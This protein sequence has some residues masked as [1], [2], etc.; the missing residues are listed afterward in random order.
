M[1]CGTCGSVLKPEMRYCPLCGVSV[2]G[3]SRK[4]KKGELIFEIRQ[5][6]EEKNYSEIAK[7]ALSGNV[8][9][10]YLYIQYAVQ[11]AKTW[12][13]SAEGTADI[14]QALE[15][16]NPAAMAIWG[17]TLYTSYRPKGIFEEIFE[18]PKYN[19]AEFEK[20]ITLVKKAA[21][22]GDAAASSYMGAW[23]AAGSLTQVLKNERDAYKYTQAAVNK[24]YPT[25]M[26]RLGT[27]YLDGINGVRKNPEL[28][29][30]LIERAAF[31]GETSAI[32]YV[33]KYNDKWLET[34]LRVLEDQ[35]Q[36][37][38]SAKLLHSSSKRLTEDI[39]F[40][41]DVDFTYD[42]ITF[43]S[44]YEVAVYKAECDFA[45]TLLFN[46]S[47][48]NDY[49]RALDIIQ[50]TRFSDYDI[51]SDIL[52][53][54]QQICK[55]ARIN[56]D[57][58]NIFLKASSQ[59]GSVKDNEIILNEIPDCLLNQLIPQLGNAKGYLLH[60]N[61]TAILENKK[62]SGMRQSLQITP[63]EP[64]YVVRPY[65]MP[66]NYYT[67]KSKGYAIAKTGIYIKAEHK[68][69]GFMK[70][71]DFG[72]T[73]IFIGDLRGGHIDNVENGQFWINDYTLIL[74]EGKAAQLQFFIS[75][76]SLVKLVHEVPSIP[77]IDYPHP[78]QKVDDNPEKVMTQTEASAE[79]V[80]P[81]AAAQTVPEPVMEVSE[82]IESKICPSCNQKNK[83]T[84]KFC[85]FC[86]SAL[87]PIQFCTQ[88]GAKL[89]P[90]KKFCSSCGAKIE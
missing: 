64:I 66:W 33:K 54:R 4:D 79:V 34:D 73:D 56:K 41:E 17:I 77:Q 11:K 57:S 1:T 67:E 61:G 40:D 81:V 24:E 72:E 26:Y 53:V 86:G 52:K 43:S 20:G 85:K 62:L 37:K 21:N 87:E 58:L 70:W 59:C 90:G 50:A 27:W 74:P 28:G 9:A 80:T 18:G 3:I 49:L 2:D 30:E 36:I 25:A 31:Y 14:K 5:L 23:C 55:L 68:K 83:A 19:D 63:D 7:R 29:Y 82:H 22:L 48:L 45:S 35:K 39:I 88:C 12:T 69:T 75:L 32:N 16:N 13:Q 15:Q 10:E 46:C 8:F 71:R 47:T 42:G 51:S 78:G 89:R 76:K 84:A 60:S 6:Q 65:G 44:G 38:R